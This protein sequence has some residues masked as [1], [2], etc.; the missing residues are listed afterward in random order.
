[1]AGPLFDPP[2]F[3]GAP[4]FKKGPRP[5]PKEAGSERGV[6]FCV[7]GRFGKNGPE[8]I[9]FVIKI[10]IK[11]TPLISRILDSPPH[12]GRRPYGPGDPEVTAGVGRD[13]LYMKVFSEPI[14]RTV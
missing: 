7:L 11:T 6:R 13:A 12:M 4:P 10:T 8:S 5:L 1:M 3:K 2:L 14:V 9:L